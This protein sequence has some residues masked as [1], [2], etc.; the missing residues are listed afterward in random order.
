MELENKVRQAGWWKSPNFIGQAS[1]DT[2]GKS[3]EYRRSSQLKS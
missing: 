1:E 3:C 2:Q